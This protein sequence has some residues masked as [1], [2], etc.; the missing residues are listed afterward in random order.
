[1][2]HKDTSALV[3]EGCSAID[4]FDR[5]PGETS[6]S[7]DIWCDNDLRTF[8]LYAAVS[9]VSQKSGFSEPGGG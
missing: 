2:I 7:V 1:M 6:G 3:K 5:D 8:E 4:V 9:K